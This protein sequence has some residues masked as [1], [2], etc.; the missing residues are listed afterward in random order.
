VISAGKIAIRPPSSERTHI[1]YAAGHWMNATGDTSPWTII[2]S[3][4]IT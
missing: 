1:L 4:V 3:V 2:L